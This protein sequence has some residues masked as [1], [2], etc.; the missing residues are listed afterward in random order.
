MLKIFE[1]LGMPALYL[2]RRFDHNAFGPMCALG[3]LSV[4]LVDLFVPEQWRLF[5]LAP[6]QLITAYLFIGYIY[7]RARHVEIG[8]QL[9]ERAANDDWQFDTQDV[10]RKWRQQGVIPMVLDYSNHVRTLTDETA[11]TAQALLNNSKATASE[12]KQLSI[13]AEEIAAMLE[14]TSAGLEQFTASINRNASNCIQ[15][16]QL[17]QKSSDAAY[18]GADQVSAINNAVN[19]TGIK[20]TKV[21]E[22]IKLIEGFAAQTNMLALNAAIEAARAG[23][24]GRGFTQ[25]ADEVREL[26]NRSAEVSK[27]IRERITLASRQIRTGMVMANDSSA[28]LENLLTQVAQ[29]KELI[30]DIANSSTEQSTGVAQIKSAVEQMAVLTQHNAAAVEQ[31]ARLANSLER[32]AFA[33]DENLVMLNASR[34]N[35]VSACKALVRRANTLVQTI[36]PEAAAEQFNQRS[37]GFHERDL[38]VILTSIK[39][40]VLA[41][42]GEPSMVG[43]DTSQNIDARGHAYVKSL[44]KVANETGSGWVKYDVRNPSNGRLAS[45]NTY[46]EK[47]PDS[48]Y[49]VCCGVFSELKIGQVK[50]PQA[51]TA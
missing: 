31:V 37:G 10:P 38:F 1:A 19:E 49:W 8:R 44:I 45:K 13:Q 50:K 48:D 16:R 11:R 42:G 24:H 39:G 40:I 6:I 7:F 26:S 23:Q 21:L 15:V 27:L 4:L 12:A 17:A 22:I 20:S 18:D 43:T 25:V 51:L 35:S 5:A 36:G 47:I 30:D 41:H 2:Y 3:V 29:T 46:V 32:E 34:F 33:I 28:I 9:L 14:E